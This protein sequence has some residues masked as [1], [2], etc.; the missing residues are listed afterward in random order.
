M[1]LIP[2]IYRFHTWLRGISPMIWR[3][4]LLR[5]D[6]TVVDLHCSLQ[7]AFGWNDSPLNRF[8]I[9]GKDFGVYHPG[10]TLFEADADS[11]FGGFAPASERAV[12]LRVRFRGQL[13][14]PDPA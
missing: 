2:E 6:Q 13:A 10:G 7:L 12:P 14:A 8:R 1:M 3:R 11:A 4:L 9:Q 5:S